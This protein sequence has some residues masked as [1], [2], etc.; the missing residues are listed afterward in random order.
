M[1]SNFVSQRKLF[2]SG[3]TVVVGRHSA[4][5][6]VRIGT[7][8][9]EDGTPQFSRIFLQVIKEINAKPVWMNIPFPS[10]DDCAWV[11]AQEQPAATQIPIDFVDVGYVERF[12]LMVIHFHGQVR[13][14]SLNR[15]TDQEKHL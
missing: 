6:L 12:Y 3:P 1:R 7:Q 13:P 8:K 2:H 11:G 4:G 10:R 5:W 14:H 15:V 9:I